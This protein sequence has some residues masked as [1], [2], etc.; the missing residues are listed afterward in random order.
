MLIPS[1]TGETRHPVGDKGSVLTVLEMTMSFH[2]GETGERMDYFWRGY[3]TDKEDKGGYK[4]MTGAEK[5][6]LLK[7]FLIPTGDDPE[8]DDQRQRKAAPPLIVPATPNRPQAPEGFVYLERID[9]K[10]T[11]TGR[12]YADVVLSTGETVMAFGEMVTLLEQLAQD[13]VAVQIETEKTKKGFLHIIEARTAAG[14]M[15][16]AEPVAPASKDIPFG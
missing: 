14:L 7:T 8:R 6:F 2:D 12:R 9:A 16:A 1:I 5:Y 11:K 10:A 15:K 3:G 4:A 13:E